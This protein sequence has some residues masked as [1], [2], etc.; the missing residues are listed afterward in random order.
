MQR[1]NYILTFLK[2]PVLLLVGLW[3]VFAVGSNAQAVDGWEKRFGDTG[4]DEASAIIQTKDEGLLLAGFEFGN[5]PIIT[6][7]DPD[8]K[9][10]WQ[11][12]YG[13]INPNGQFKDIIRLEDDYIAV[14]YII[15]ANGRDVFIQKIDDAGNDLG[16]IAYGSTEDEEALGATATSDGGFAVVGYKS[17][18]DGEEQIYLLKLNADL[19]TLW[20]KTFGGEYDDRGNSIIESQVDDNLVIAG[21]TELNSNAPVGLL[22]QTDA[23][24]NEN[25]FQQIGSNVARDVVENPA[26]GSFAIAAYSNSPGSFSADLIIRNE[27][28]GPISNTS[29]GNEDYA[30]EFRS[31]VRAKTGGYL[32]AGFTETSPLEIDAYIV[33]IDEN[34][35]WEWDKSFGLPNLPDEFLSV[36]NTFDGGYVMAGS[37]T[38]TGFINTD[39]YI[40]KTNDTGDIYSNYITGNIFQD[41]NESCDLDPA[42]AP[43]DGWIIKAISDEHTC[44][45]TSDADGNY[46]ILTNTGTYTIEAEFPNAYWTSCILQQT[47]NFTSPYDTFDLDFAVQVEI[48]C[49]DIEVD[50]TTAGLTPGGTTRYWV[51]YCNKGTEFADD[52]YI[53]VEFDESYV[54]IGSNPIP[55]FIGDGV[56]RFED[57]G[58][59]APFDCSEFWIDVAIDAS[60]V[61]GQTHSVKAFAYPNEICETVVDGSHLVVDTE[62]DGDDVKLTITNVGTGGMS[63]ATDFV[64]VEDMLLLKK[65]PVQLGVGQD[66]VITIPATDDGKTYRI[67]VD[68][69]PG[70]LGDS[71]PSEAIEG[72]TT[73]ATFS[74]GYVNQFPEDDY[75]HFLSV[76]CQENQ[77]IL[78]NESRGYPKGYDSPIPNAPEH[79]IQNCADLKYHHRFFYTGPDTAIRVVIRDT[80]SP[81]LDPASVRPGVSNHEYTMDV[82]ACGILKFT[83]ENIMLNGSST[84][85]AESMVYVKYR[86]SQRLNIPDGSVVDNSAAAYFDYLSPVKTDSIFHTIASC[87]LEEFVLVDPNSSVIHLPG[88]EAIKVYP[89]PFVDQATVEVV[90]DQQLED[91]RFKL[92][93]M[94]GRMIRNESFT[95]MTYQLQRGQLTT[96]MYV[97]KIESK[98]VDVSSGKLMVR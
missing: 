32:L 8:G 25:W 41:L 11:E 86:V 22:L 44:Y 35:A 64:I 23:D 77:M 13:Q 43:I 84:D 63:T 61:D 75:D 80:L 72:C 59:L 91:M 60:S 28:G 6:K 3:M 58:D 56:F 42:D 5:R 19:D 95:G 49:T 30:D 88:V 55:I 39:F 54:F 14:G 24:G 1:A 31:I 15:D 10:L 12:Q 20:T 66:T 69:T 51:D 85:P 90:A 26:D 92:Y 87:D 48:E 52:P 71:R 83:F 74:T 93:D 46:T 94:T 21:F 97:Y 36:A 9:I 68:Q 38:L 37:H 4:T 62:C 96:G 17:N 73:G 70:H 81:L 2:R 57:L 98:G 7:T 34:G 40:L 50:I 27:F 82:Y 45:G 89:N 47:I 33:K 65:D 18:T 79:Q 67:M 76:D 78:G 53:D 29:F 16:S